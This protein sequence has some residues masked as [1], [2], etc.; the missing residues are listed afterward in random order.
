M[1][2]GSIE[3][4]TLTEYMDIAYFP[5]SLCYVLGTPPPN[6]ENAMGQRIPAEKKE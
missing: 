6:N 5:C 4:V 2:V 3:V 1:K